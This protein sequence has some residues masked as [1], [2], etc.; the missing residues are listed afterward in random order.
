MM[1]DPHSS[2]EILSVSHLNRRCRQLLETQLPM[3][4]VEGEISN[5][6]HP[7]SGHWYFTLKDDQAQV[8]CAMFKNRNQ[9]VTFSP[10]QGQHVLLRAR[11][12]LYEGRGDYQLIAEHMEEAGLGRLQ[13]E[14]EALKKKLASEGLFDPDNKRPLPTLPQHVAVITSPTGAAIRDILA[15]L[16]RRFPACKV[17]VVPAPVQGREAAGHLREAL[18]L[19]LRANLFDAIII[20]RCGG[21]LEDLWAFNDEALARAIAA[22]PVPI[23]SA[24]GHEIDF[25]IA[26]FVADVRAATPSNAAEIVVDRADN[27]IARIDRA[28]R[29]LRAALALAVARRQQR[30]HV[31]DTRL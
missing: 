4:W 28:E 15:V 23:I 5:L 29:R 20:G 24:V 12:S 21:S 9:A 8:R 18:A 2:R 16:Q 1:I 25:T 31:L 27:F 26:D 13:R 11:A 17:T 14:F 3:V 7:S 6:A 30:L 22:S 19:A 10:E